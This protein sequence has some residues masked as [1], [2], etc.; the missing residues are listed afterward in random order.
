[1]RSLRSLWRLILVS[2]Y[3]AAVRTP[4]RTVG[5]FFPAIFANNYCHLVGV[6]FVIIV[7]VNSV[8]TV[9]DARFGAIC[10]VNVLALGEFF[11]EFLVFVGKVFRRIN[12]YVDKLIALVGTVD[13]G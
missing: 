8:D 4:R 9:K 6:L 10:R 12:V 13:C 7:I 2:T 11:N 5:E 1:M 3:I